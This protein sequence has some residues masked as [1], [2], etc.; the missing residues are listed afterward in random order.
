[1]RQARLVRARVRPSMPFHIGPDISP[2]VVRA[3]LVLGLTQKELGAMFHASMRTAHRWEGGRSHP[4]VN[5]V[6]KL[7]SAVFP[8]DAQLAAELAQEAG[9][10]LQAMGLIPAPAAPAAAAP[11]P[12]PRPFPPVAL[13]TDSIV[14]AAVDA[15]EGLTATAA[16]RKDVRDI[17]RAG[18]ARAHELGLTLEEVNL[19]LE[20]PPPA[21]VA[22]K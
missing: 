4:D 8:K 9:T 12:P 3:R 22:K 15:A 7:A 2:L 18:F 10:T 1:M 14:L 11:A 17:L 13:M 19:A 5:Q 16:T 6:L 20:V 21:R